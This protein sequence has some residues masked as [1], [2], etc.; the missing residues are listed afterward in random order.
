ME[1][2]VFLGP[3]LGRHEAQQILPARYLP[4]VAQSDLFSAVEKYAPKVIVIV[5]GVFGQSL[6]VWHKEILYALSRGIHV[7]GCSSM[8]AL[9]AAET[10]HYGM[11]GFGEIYEMYASGEL[12]DDDE[13]ALWHL[14]EEN[15]YLNICEPMVNIRQT[16]AFAL[17]QNAIS[18]Q[19][20]DKLVAI[21]KDLYYPKR[22]IAK[23]VGLAHQEEALGHWNKEE[24]ISYLTSNYVDQKQLD[25]VNLLTHLA[26]NPLSQPFLP[27][28]EF[29]SSMVFKAQTEKDRL[30]Y[31]ETEKAT[32][33]NIARQYVLQNREATHIQ[34]QALDK[35]FLV[36]QGRALGVCV[37]DSDIETETRRYRK[38]SHLEDTSRFQRW[39]DEND[40]NDRD[41]AA[42][43]K[44]EAIC[45]KVRKWT[46]SQ[47]FHCS[48]CGALINELKLQN[49]Y[50]EAKQ[51]ALDVNRVIKDNS[52]FVREDTDMHRALLHII[53]ENN[54]T[55]DTN[56]KEWLEEQGFENYQ[57]LLNEAR[58]LHMVR[59][60]KHRRIADMFS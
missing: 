21:G 60:F 52:L 49:K 41:F 1:I 29:Y 11:R 17:K 25:A 13:V 37:S 39:L 26:T 2:I 42:L 30:V 46:M 47:L 32:V 55:L 31:S 59:Q 14:D 5:D 40:L 3:S 6:S 36:E 54:L 50:P 57:N 35:V 20:H 34:N 27:E 45:R 48:S 53:K 58:R 7:L 33:S 16:L 9:R 56:L 44:V 18:E 43:M 4:P 15:D 51:K 8:G 19:L 24:L 22:S 23:I 28:F 38:S 10:S 12:Q